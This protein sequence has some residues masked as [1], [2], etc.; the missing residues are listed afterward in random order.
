MVLR[1]LSGLWVLPRTGPGVGR[2]N[3]RGRAP[4]KQALKGSRRFR[5]DGL[6]KMFII[7]NL[8]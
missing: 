7:Y 5:S 3:I 2:E 4:G 6:L 1:V 8:S